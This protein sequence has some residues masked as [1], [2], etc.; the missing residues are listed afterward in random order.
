MIDRPGPMSC[1]VLPIQWPAAV[2]ALGFRLEPWQLA[3]VESWYQDTTEPRRVPRIAPTRQPRSAPVQYTLKLTWWLT[4]RDMGYP[5]RER[6][7]TAQTPPAIHVHASSLIRA[8]SP[9]FSIVNIEMTRDF[10]S[11]QT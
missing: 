10:V 7:F 9:S 4:P 11:S 8:L 6:L 2:R 5:W 1:S 3:I